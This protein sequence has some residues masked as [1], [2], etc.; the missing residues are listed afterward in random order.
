MVN[1]I[2]RESGHV[3]AKLRRCRAMAARVAGVLLL[4]LPVFPA[5]PGAMAQGF[6]L[7]DEIISDPNTGAALLGF[8]PVA[9]FVRRTAVAGDP[10]HQAQHGG[11]VWYFESDANRAAFLRNP[12]SYLPAFGGH[13][14]VAIAAGFA[15]SGSPEIFAIAGDRV[16]LFR[17]GEA[18]EAFL[19]EPGIAD[20][21]SRN[22]PQVKRNMVP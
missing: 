12:E 3:A 17:K 18:R 21:A 7:S 11:K 13:D 9:Y 1:E 16:Y 8:D 5:G 15:V 10:A 2:D 4:F 6:S 14:P 22:W 19:R 20:A